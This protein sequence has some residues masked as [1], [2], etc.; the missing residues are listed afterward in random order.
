[1]SN[2]NNTADITT[3]ESTAQNE[4]KKAAEVYFEDLDLSE[5]VLDAL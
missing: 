3:E 1:M 4:E 2:D 5:N